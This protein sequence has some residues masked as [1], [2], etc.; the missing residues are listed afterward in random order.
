MPKPTSLLK[1]TASNPIFLRYLLVFSTTLSLGVCLNFF[2][3]AFAAASFSHKVSPDG[4][5]F[6]NYERKML[7]SAK[8]CVSLKLF[9]MGCFGPS[10]N[11]SCTHPGSSMLSSTSTDRSFRPPKKLSCL[12]DIFSNFFLWFSDFVSKLAST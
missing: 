6:F 8:K 9:L 5:W 3:Y 12:S 7:I 2:A 1:D 11:T 4:F 10:G